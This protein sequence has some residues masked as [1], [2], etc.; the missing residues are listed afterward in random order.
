MIPIYENA[1]IRF[2]YPEGWTVDET[3]SEDGPTISLQ[4]PFSMFLFITLYDCSRTAQD[5]ADQALGAMQEEY[6]EMDVEPAA[7]MIA[8]RAAVGHDVNFFSLDLTNTCWI[9]ALTASR[10]T[11][12]LFA[13]AND[14]D[15]ETAEPTLRAI[16]ASLKLC[17]PANGAANSRDKPTDD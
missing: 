11:V 8:E 1:V 13:Q 10:H 17:E 12:L 15:L 5:V 3:E 6:A 14:L 16:F 9:R 4:S 2:A 7:E